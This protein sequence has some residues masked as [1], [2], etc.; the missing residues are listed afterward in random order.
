VRRVKRLQHLDVVE[1]F[2]QGVHAGSSQK[3]LRRGRKLR[4]SR[5]SNS[6]KDMCRGVAVKRSKEASQVGEKTTSLVERHF[7]LFVDFHK[8]E[9]MD[10]IIQGY[11]ARVLEP[12]D[13]SKTQGGYNAGVERIQSSGEVAEFIQD[14]QVGG[15][16]KRLPIGTS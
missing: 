12:L 6:S 11:F 15:L 2:P 10:E 14:G 16:F 4:R 8:E 7:F 3:D 13:L 9:W 1:D 5:P